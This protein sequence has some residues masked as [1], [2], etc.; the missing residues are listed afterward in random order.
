MHRGGGDCGDSVTKRYIYQTVNLS[1]EPKPDP[2]GFRK[3][4]FET[5]ANRWAEMGWRTIAVIPSKGPSYADSILVE[6][7]VGE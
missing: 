3:A 7:E 5:A 4:T 2:G 6:K 1:L